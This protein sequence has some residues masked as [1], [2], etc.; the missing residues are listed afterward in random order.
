MNRSA[1]FV[2]AHLG[3]RFCYRQP[4]QRARQIVLVTLSQRRRVSLL[5]RQTT[6]RHSEPEAKSLVVGIEISPFTNNDILPFDRLRTTLK[7]VPLCGRLAVDNRSR[8]SYNSYNETTHTCQF[9]ST[10]NSE[11]EE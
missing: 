2:P 5:A 10:N 7:S 6:L 8:I 9:Y 11:Q 4:Y 1:S 3:G